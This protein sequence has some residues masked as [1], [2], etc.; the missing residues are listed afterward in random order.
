MALLVVERGYLRLD[1]KLKEQLFRDS[2]Y[3]VITEFFAAL[4]EAKSSTNDPCAKAVTSNTQLHAE[5][6]RGFNK[7]KINKNGTHTFAALDKR[8][9]SCFSYCLNH[10]YFTFVHVFNRTYIAIE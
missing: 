10:S 8:P 1:L 2:P 9:S 6:I 3:F 4:Q 7:K 5:L